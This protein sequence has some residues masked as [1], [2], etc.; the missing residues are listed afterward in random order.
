MIILKDIET[1]K[2][3]LSVKFDFTLIDAFRLFKTI[4]GTAN[5]GE[6]TRKEVSQGLIFNL[7]FSDF[8]AED[9]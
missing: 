3:D 5:Q 1:T 8:S 9:I 7:E 4:T 2:I 6:I